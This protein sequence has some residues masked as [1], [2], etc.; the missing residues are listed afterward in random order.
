MKQTMR[1][2]NLADR[3]NL[4]DLTLLLGS[5]FLQGNGIFVAEQTNPLKGWTA[6][7]IEVRKNKSTFFRFALSVYFVK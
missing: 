4:S 3:P 7:F 5:A 1:C 6:F 2:P